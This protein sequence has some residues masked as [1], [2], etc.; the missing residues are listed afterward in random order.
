MS[1]EIVPFPSPK[2]QVV[3]TLLSTA[4][5]NFETTSDDDL[6]AVVEKASDILNDVTHDDHDVAVLVEG[7]TVR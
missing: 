2:R 5:Q 4:V 3:K 7:E 1:C 6:L